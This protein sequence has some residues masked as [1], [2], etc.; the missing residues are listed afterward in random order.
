MSV[1]ISAPALPTSSSL[2]SA[3]PQGPPFRILHKSADASYLKVHHKFLLSMRFLGFSVLGENAES[4]QTAE[5]V[6]GSSLN[7]RPK[8]EEL[9]VNA[10]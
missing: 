4:E 10:N 9:L 6:L 7:L 5:R 1:S 2:F 3:L 8:V